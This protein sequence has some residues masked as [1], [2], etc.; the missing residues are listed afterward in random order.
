MPFPAVD[1]VRYERNPIELVVCQLRFPPILRIEADI[2]SKFQ[3]MIRDR[4]PLYESKS[5]LNL[6][7]GLPA[8]LASFFQNLPLGSSPKAHDFINANRDWTITLDRESLTLSCRRYES[9]EQFK[10]HL[11]APLEALRKEYSPPFY[12]RIG[13]R[14]RD[15]IRPSKLG[16]EGTGWDELLNSWIAGPYGSKE[17][18]GDIERTAHQALI[19]LPDGKGR[20]LLNHGLLVDSQDGKSCYA[21]DSDFYADGQTEDDNAISRL[22]SFNLQARYFFRWCISSRLHEAMGPRPISSP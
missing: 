11:S 15:V 13:L 1:R 22:D 4:Y 12:V 5:V 14:Y 8:E 7:P 2:P 3:D 18:A 17:V 21:I 10:E 9:W 6:S 19:R 20:V 16:L